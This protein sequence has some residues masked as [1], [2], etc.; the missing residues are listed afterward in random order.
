[1]Y[2]SRTLLGQVDYKHLFE[3]LG[4]CDVGGYVWILHRAKPTVRYGLKENCLRV[5]IP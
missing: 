2:A 3:L 4:F 1:M 5:L